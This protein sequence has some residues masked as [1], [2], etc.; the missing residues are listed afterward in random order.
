MPVPHNDRVAM[1]GA[2]TA[3]TVPVAFTVPGALGANCTVTVHD[4]RGPKLLPVHVSAV[5]VNASAPDNDTFFTAR[6]AL[7]PE[8]LNVN[9][10]DT[11]RPDTLTFPKSYGDGVNASDGGA[12]LEAPATATG[13]T[14]N[15]VATANTAATTPRSRIMPPKSI[16]PA[17]RTRLPSS[18]KP[19][20]RNAANSYAP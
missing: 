17:P 8:F 5:T 3:S 9:G 13:D 4:L 16:G 1:A 7:K 18:L 11:G 6:D 14:A 12:A 2:L 10:C 20:R 19:R 15:I